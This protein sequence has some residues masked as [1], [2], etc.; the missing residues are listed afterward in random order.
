MKPNDFVVHFP[1]I[2]AEVCGTLI[3][4]FEQHPESHVRRDNERQQFTE[5]NLHDVEPELARFIA[6]NG[7]NR[8]A[9]L[10]ADVNLPWGDR[11]FPENWGLEQIRIKRYNEG[12]WFKQHVDIGNLD[13]SKRFLAFL[14][15]L[16]DDFEGG[17]TL[18]KTPDAHVIR[19][20]TGNVVVFPPTWQYPHEGTPVKKGIKYIMSSY[21][22]YV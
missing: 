5:L 1:I 13:S 12:D 21:L 19:P 11:F 4:T 20:L 16:N 9:E 18:F 3:D 8:A 22:N 14:F 2:T 10:Y 6:V 17:D 7:V 15:Y